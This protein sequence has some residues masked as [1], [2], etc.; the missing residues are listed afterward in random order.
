MQKCIKNN[1]YLY[2]N[3]FN[4]NKLDSNSATN[5]ILTIEQEDERPKIYAKF[6]DTDFFIWIYKEKNNLL[7]FFIGD[8]CVAW[9]K[10]FM[11]NHYGIDFARYIRLLLRVCNEF[12]ILSLETDAF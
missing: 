7:N 5:L 2:K 11:D 1:V 8:F 10:E 4:L 3:P 6:Q 12:T 9:K